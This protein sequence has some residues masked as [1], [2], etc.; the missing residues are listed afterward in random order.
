M[1]RIFLTLIIMSLLLTSCTKKDSVNDK[2]DI[3]QDNNEKIIATWI[4]YYEIKQ[5]VDKSDNEGDFESLVCEKIRNLNRYSINNIFLHVRAFDDSF[6]KSD[7]FPVSSYC[8][9]AKGNLKFDVLQI[10]LKVCHSLN[11]KVHAWINPYRIR[12][13]SDISKINEKS[14]AYQLLNGD[15][16]KLIKTDSVI[17]YNPS[18][19][20]I[21]LYVLDGVREILDNY[22]VDGIHIDDY[23]YPTTS[24]D[25]DE[26][27]YEKYEKAG[28]TLELD[29]FRRQN[30]DSLVSSIY[31][32]VKSYNDRLVFSISPSGD[33]NKNL[34][35]LYADVVLWMKT[36]G[37]ADYIIPQIY[38]GYDNENMPF[39]KVLNEWIK[40][41]GKKCKIVIGL[42]LYKSGSIDIYA[43]KGKNEWIDYSDI[44]SRQIRLSF[45]NNA[46]GVSF[47]SYSYLIDFNENK[48]ITAER[49]NI[50][51]QMDLYV[52]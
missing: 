5:L 40:I 30:V 9:D 28:G 15:S 11:V 41:A 1:K 35:E 48:V 44:L 18:Y 24:I 2:S 21:Q 4:T 42:G 47:Y 43:G 38:Y 27:A 49:E 22:S 8:S 50:L 34:N 6:Y 25:I 19:T 37:Y 16:E 14:F 39:Q 33:I 36:A 46:D 10:F 45:D 29:D 17:Y 31:S 3:S 7:I 12:N 52:T 26:K 20:D 23:F 32:L 51:K 13:D